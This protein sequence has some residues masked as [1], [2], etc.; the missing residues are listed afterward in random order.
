MRGVIGVRLVVL[1][2]A[3]MLPAG[4]L[5]AALW[6]LG[7]G[8]G[9]DPETVEAAARKV[10]RCCDGRTGGCP[11]RTRPSSGRVVRRVPSNW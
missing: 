6:L 9:R 10:V 2:A 3:G 11:G 8:D 5:V 7:R 4:A 1:W